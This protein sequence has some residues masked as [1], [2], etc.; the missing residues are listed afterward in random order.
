MSASANNDKRGVPSSGAESSKT[1]KEEMAPIPEIVE[2]KRKDAEG[3]YVVVNRYIRGKLLGKVSI[4]ILLLL[5]LVLY[6]YCFII[7]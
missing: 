4:S 1:N 7:N 2:E 6:K 5:L 3:R